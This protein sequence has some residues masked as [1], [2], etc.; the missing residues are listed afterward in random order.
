MIVIPSHGGFIPFI[1]IYHIPDLLP[2][3]YFIAVAVGDGQRI[4]SKVW[5][6][7]IIS[8]PVQMLMLLALIAGVSYVVLSVMADESRFKKYLSL[9]MYSSIPVWLGALLGVE[10]AA[11][12][13][14]APLAVFV[15]VVAREFVSD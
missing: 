14:V 10:P 5:I 12:V 11:D 9:V 1:G 6:V 7:G 2:P 15:L 3:D 8:T 4:R 13:P